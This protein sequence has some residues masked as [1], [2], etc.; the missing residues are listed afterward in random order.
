M[1]SINDFK[2]QMIDG[3]ARSN[4]FYVQLQ[5]PTW[6]PFG[7]VQGQRAQFLCKAAQLPASTIAD[8]EVQYRGRQIHFAG[9]RTFQPW[10]VTILNDSTFGIRNALEAWQAGIQDYDLTTG[11]LPPSSYQVDMSVY[12]LDRNGNELKMYQFADTYPSTISTIQLSFDQPNVI[13]EYE[14]EFVY[15]YFTSKTGATPA[16]GSSVGFNTSINTPIGTF[17]IS[18]PQF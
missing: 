8:V 9:E 12:Q 4:Q 15:N 6:V 3:G 2:A 13:E 18:T 1:A 17:P 5:F 11:M 10:I 7:M 16:G 14:V